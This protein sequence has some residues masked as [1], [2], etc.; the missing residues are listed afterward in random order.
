MQYQNEVGQSF[1]GLQTR[2][3]AQLATICAS[4]GSLVTAANRFAAAAEDQAEAQ[5]EIRQLLLSVKHRLF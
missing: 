1:V 3:Q 5:R 2:Q 4:L